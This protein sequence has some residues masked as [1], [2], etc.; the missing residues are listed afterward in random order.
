MKIKGKVW[1]FGDHINT[2]DII[3]ARYLNTTDKKGEN[4]KFEKCDK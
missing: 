4:E 2:D 3:A 1:K